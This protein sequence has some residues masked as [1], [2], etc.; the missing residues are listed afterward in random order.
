MAG[1]A[2]S[3]Q[4]GRENL[5]LF[6]NKDFEAIPGKGIRGLLLIGGEKIRAAIGNQEMMKQEG[7]QFASRRM[8]VVYIKLLIMPTMD[9]LEV[10]AEEGRI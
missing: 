8:N 3:T 10:L 4:G 9:A 5:E 2:S 1:R 6:E 7:I